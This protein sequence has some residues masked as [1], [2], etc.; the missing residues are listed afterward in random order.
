MRLNASAMWMPMRSCR[1]MIGADVCLG[2]R[3]DHRVDRVGD[4]RLDAL[5]LQDLGNR[6]LDLHAFPLELSSGWFGK[7]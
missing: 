5:A 3:L 4:Q 2:R 1:T 7:V 6:V